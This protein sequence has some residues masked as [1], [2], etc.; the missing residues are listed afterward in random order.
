MSKTYAALKRAE[1]ERHGAR[2]SANGGNGTD[3]RGAPNADPP[4]PAHLEYE[5]IRVWLKNPAQRE[6]RIQAVMVV[7]CHSGAGA[8]TTAA[9]LATTLA[10]GKRSRVVL[11]DTNFRTPGP[12]FFFRTEE[13]GET[14]LL[15]ADELPFAARLQ[16]TDRENLFVLKCDQLP[17]CPL[18]V[19]EGDEIIDLIAETKKGF[20]FVVFD[21]PPVLDYPDSYALASKVDGIILVAESER[22]LIED[23]QRAKRDLE[24]AGGKVLGVVLNRHVSYL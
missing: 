16:R 12:N 17:G 14:A 13:E 8:S 10:E 11:I 9:L 18:E 7:A 15:P 22:T 1:E 21:A 19:F 6:Q 2:P 5:K 3:R 4:S 23:A 24:R 20:D